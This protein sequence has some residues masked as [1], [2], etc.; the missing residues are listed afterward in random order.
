[1]ILPKI[2]SALHFKHYIL[3]KPGY[4]A[5]FALITSGNASCLYLVNPPHTEHSMTCENIQDTRD[6]LT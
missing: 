6:W 2:N 1:M 5:D 3:K 4:K